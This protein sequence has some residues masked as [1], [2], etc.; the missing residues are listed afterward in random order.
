MVPNQERAIDKPRG[1]A[2]D[3]LTAKAMV[4]LW[5]YHAADVHVLE[6]RRARREFYSD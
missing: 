3:V 4:L 1:T 6:S 5:S 2:Q